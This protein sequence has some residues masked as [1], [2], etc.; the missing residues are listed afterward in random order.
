M[1]MQ[2]VRRGTPA[3][4]LAEGAGVPRISMLL[5]FIHLKLKLIKVSAW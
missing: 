5:R 4:E 2:K 1:E 3:P